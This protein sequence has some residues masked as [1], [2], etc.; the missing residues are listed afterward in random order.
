MVAP[1]QPAEPFAAQDRS[2]PWIWF[3]W[4]GD[5]SIADALVRPLSG[6]QI[7]GVG[8]TEKRSNDVV[9]VG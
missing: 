6:G 9:F 8:D 5:E 7:W 1:E 3:F 4:F 2:I